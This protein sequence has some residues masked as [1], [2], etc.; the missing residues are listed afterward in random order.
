[1]AV[2]PPL[3]QL[4]RLPVLQNSVSCISLELEAVAS[5]M[6]TTM[7]AWHEVPLF[8]IQ[9]PGDSSWSQGSA[10]WMRALEEAAPP[11]ANSKQAWRL[12]N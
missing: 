11:I 6:A 1:M 7:Q 4:P 3:T 9:L 10:F 2:A 5:P 8:F 12:L